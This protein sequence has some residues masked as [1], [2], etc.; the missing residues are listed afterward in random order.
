M[1]MRFPVGPMRDQSQFNPWL[2]LSPEERLAAERHMIQQAPPEQWN[3]LVAPTDPRHPL[4]VDMGNMQQNQYE[5]ML[6]DIDTG[7]KENVV[8]PMAEAGYPNLGAGV[9]AVGMAGAEMFIPGPNEGLPFGGGLGH[10]GMALPPKKTESILDYMTPEAREMAEQRVREMREGLG[11]GDEAAAGPIDPYAKEAEQAN[12]YADMMKKAE[13]LD[14]RVLDP[15]TGLPM[16]RRAPDSPFRET[17]EPE[18]VNDSDQLKLLDELEKK[19]TTHLQDMFD[20]PDT[21]IWQEYWDDGSLDEGLFD[22]WNMYGNTDVPTGADEAEMLADRLRYG[23]YIGDISKKIEDRMD[24]RNLPQEFRDWMRADDKYNG[25]LNDFDE[26]GYTAEFGEMKKEWSKEKAEEIVRK[27]IDEYEAYAASPDAADYEL[28]WQDPVEWDENYD[29][30]VAPYGKE[31]IYGENTR[32]RRFK[33]DHTS[34]FD[35]IKNISP[36]KDKAKQVIN[37]I[38]DDHV[39]DFYNQNS[40]DWWDGWATHKRDQEIEAYLPDDENLWDE[41]TIKEAYEDAFENTAASSQD[42]IL[43]TIGG[44]LGDD[45]AKKIDAD[46]LKNIVDDI[47]YRQKA[48][49]D[50]GYQANIEGDEANIISEFK[51]E[52]AKKRLKANKKLKVVK[53]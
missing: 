51:S 1:G 28:E 24:D 18:V 44:V 34:A 15:D 32:K 14:A 23:D 36:N 40:E 42:E 13:D 20:D 52:K 38:Y 17:P 9:G 35:A 50:K 46:R 6:K 37:D 7:I 53:P 4:N 10:L 3:N 25:I 31:G 33:N 49:F 45:V 11:Y 21:H 27:K 2:Y 12:P 39:D 5:N 26:D 47:R 30:D 19:D 41:N 29:F 48:V 22:D 16:E 8:Y 43:E